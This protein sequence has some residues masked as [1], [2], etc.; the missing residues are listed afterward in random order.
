MPAIALLDMDVRDGWEPACHPA[1][2]GQLTRIDC[3]ALGDVPLERYAGLIVAGAAVDQEYLH[4]Q[5][6]RIRAYLDAGGVVVFGGHLHRPWLPGT[7]L[8][9][10]KRVRSH[11]DYMVRIVADHP[12]LV[13]VDARDL[14]FRRGVAGFFAR[15]HHPAPPGAEVLV[16]FV[17]GEPVTYV[18]RATTA[19][20]IL[21]Q[22][23]SHPLAHGGS[24]TTAER[25]PAQLLVWISTVT[26]TG[27]GADRRQ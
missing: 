21:V 12:V 10:P 26:R 4:R 2:H 27:S 6:D 1:L 25:I 22:A 9:V 15:G 5:R 17:S 13:G 7:G 20:T 16:A 19:G 8:F 24:G 14:T 11:H 18:D 23:T 3:Y